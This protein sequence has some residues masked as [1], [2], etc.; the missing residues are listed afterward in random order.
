MTKITIGEIR[1]K[2]QAKVQPANEE[3]QIRNSIRRQIKKMKIGES[4]KIKGISE[5]DLLSLRS[6]IAYYAKVDHFKVKTS[7]TGSALEIYR[8]RVN[9]SS[10]A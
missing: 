2:S 3:K 4:F 7:F 8:V 5:S 9:Q 1:R 6:V 10:N